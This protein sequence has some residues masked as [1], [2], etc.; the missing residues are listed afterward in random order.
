MSIYQKK[1]Y[2]PPFSHIYCEKEIYDTKKAQEIIKKFKNS[3]VILI[4]HYKDIFCRKHQNS[5]IQKNSQNLII[6]QNKGCLIYKGAPVCQNFGNSEFY[7]TTNAINCVYDCEYCFLQ[8]M[9]PSSNIVLFINFYDYKKSILQMLKKNNVY[10][11][12]S[13]DTDLLAIENLFGSCRE[14]IEFAREEKKLKIEIRT[15]SANFN[16]ISDI[17]PCPNVILAWTLSPDNLIQ[18]YEHKTPCINKRIENIKKAVKFGWKVRICL[19][20]LIYTDK[21]KIYYTELIENIFKNIP[22]EKINDISIGAFRMSSEYLK[23]I[24]RNKTNSLIINY[25]FET[26]EGICHYN[27][28]IEKELTSFVYDKIKKYMDKDKIFVWKE[29]V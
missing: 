22:I 15:K 12:V 2:N 3:R 10:L 11:C 17:T 29:N 25:P 13:F 18:A 5:F 19:D 28:E 9:Y 7:Y 16:L 23:K 4:E 26:T 6:A 1:S 21:Y 24:R 27:N 20:P 8:G 14:W